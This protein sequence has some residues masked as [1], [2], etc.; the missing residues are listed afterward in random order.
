VIISKNSCT[1]TTACFTVTTVGINSQIENIAISI[2]PNPNTGLFQIDVSQPV[3]MSIIDL[4]GKIVLRQA[5]E[6]GSTT[7]Q[8][9][10]LSGVYFVRIQSDKDTS[11]HKI[12]IE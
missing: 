1:D 3:E 4:A 11:I 2:H 10:N 6:N 7:I 8:T 9:S 5:I 12:I